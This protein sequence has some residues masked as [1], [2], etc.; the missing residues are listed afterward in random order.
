MKILL[1]RH[2]KAESRSLS[3]S[4]DDRKLT[5]EGHRDLQEHMPY[6]NEYLRDTKVTL[7]SSP[8][9]RAIETAQYLNRELT[10]VDFL[11]TGNFDEFSHCVNQHDDNDY[12]VFVGHEPIL[13]I[14]IERL[15]GELIEVKK[16]MAI[17]IEWPNTLLQA[18]K[19]KEY[20]HF[21]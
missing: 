18:H 15:T 17:E 2:G 16:G 20:K 13:S 11:E 3:L 12:L 10:E 5:K 1:I 4:D 19:L 7:F 14:W 21:K 6:L 9:V 8:L